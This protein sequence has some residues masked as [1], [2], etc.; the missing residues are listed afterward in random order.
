MGIETWPV[1]ED[2]VEA[3]P[4]TIDNFVEWKW[5]TDCLFHLKAPPKI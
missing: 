3:E 2:Y 1:I 4:V 5:L